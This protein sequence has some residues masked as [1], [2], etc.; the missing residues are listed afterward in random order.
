MHEQ[1]GP[2]RAVGWE[3]EMLRNF[4]LAVSEYNATLK[5]RE[6]EVFIGIGHF[7]AQPLR[8][9]D[10]R[11]H[12]CRACYGTLQRRQRPGWREVRWAE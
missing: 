3:T 12:V 2:D 10:Q 5:C 6:C 11:G 8:A 1:Q 9:P 7:D 4:P